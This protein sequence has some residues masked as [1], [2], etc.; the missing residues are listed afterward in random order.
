MKHRKTK[1]PQKGSSFRLPSKSY[2]VELDSFGGKF[3]S[4]ILSRKLQN[5]RAT[6][7]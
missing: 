2:S 5:F 7:A 3:I 4:A 6:E 1:P